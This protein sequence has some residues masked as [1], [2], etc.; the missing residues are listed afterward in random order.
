MISA[1]QSTRQYPVSGVFALTVRR[2]ET[3]RHFFDAAGKCSRPLPF[4]VLPYVGSE[5]A[6]VVTSLDTAAAEPELGSS[7]GP[8]QEIV[9]IQLCLK[10]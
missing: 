4:N 10:D 8:G 1:S 5:K 9:I 6:F 7:D 3:F 2:P